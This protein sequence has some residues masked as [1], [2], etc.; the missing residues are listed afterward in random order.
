MARDLSIPLKPRP[1]LGLTASI[2]TKMNP[3]EK[4]ASKSR[5]TCFTAIDVNIHENIVIESPRTKY[6]LP[7]QLLKNNLTFSGS[8]DADF[9]KSP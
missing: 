3:T 6:F 7:S 5:N 8:F 2:R 1:F 4:T 9:C